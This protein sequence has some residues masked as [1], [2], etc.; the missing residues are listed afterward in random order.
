MAKLDPISRV[1]YKTKAK[2][3]KEEAV[4]KKMEELEKKRKE[5]EA[6]KLYEMEAESDFDEE[7]PK[8]LVSSSVQFS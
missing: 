1:V 6:K 5:E 8:P 7:D 4:K 3:D 2:L